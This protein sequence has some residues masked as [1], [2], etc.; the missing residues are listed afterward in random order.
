MGLYGV[1]TVG[2]RFF[3]VFGPRQD[4]SSSYSGVISRFVERAL[5]RQPLV[6]FG[7]GNQLRDFVHVRDAVS[8]LIR[9]MDRL[10]VSQGVLNVCTGRPTTI[11]DLIEILAQIRDERPRIEFQPARD[12]DIRVSLGD[13]LRAEEWLG[14]KAK[15]TIEEGLRELL[16]EQG[17]VIRT[18]AQIRH[19]GRF[20]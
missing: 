6:V 17:P 2:L 12:G 8:A 14:F 4:A 18:G 19:A 3:N 5:R 9:A 11:L 16:G 13:P 15:V 1:P 20:N 7:D 10:P